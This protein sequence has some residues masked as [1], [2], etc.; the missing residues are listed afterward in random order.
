MLNLAIDAM[1]ILDIIVNFNT[2]YSKEV[3]IIYDRKLIARKYI[4]TRFTVD[5]L[6]AM[7][8]DL[9]AGVFFSFSSKEL[10][11]LSLLKLIRMLRLSRIIRALNVQRSIKSKVK[12]L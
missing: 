12:L 11:I 3:D 6:S 4:K 1:F 7:P 8:L 2:S 5:I 10:K 9:I